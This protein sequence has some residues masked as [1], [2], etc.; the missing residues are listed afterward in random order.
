MSR[1]SKSKYCGG[2]DGLFAGRAGLL[3][4]EGKLLNIHRRVLHLYEEESF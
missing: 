3:D 4:F 2:Q 1:T